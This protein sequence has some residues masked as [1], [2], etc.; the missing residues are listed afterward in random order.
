MTAPTY[1]LQGPFHR[2]GRR[3]RACPAVLSAAH[4]STTCA[5]PE[6][7]FRARWSPTSDRAPVSPP[8]SF[9]LAATRSSVSSPTPRCELQQRTRWRSTRTFVRRRDRPRRPACR[10]GARPRRRGAGFSL[11]RRRPHAR[12]VPAHSQGR[13]LGGAD[14]ERPPVHRYRVP[15]RR[16]KLCCSNSA[17]TMPRSGIAASATERLADFFGGPF[18]TRRYDNSPGARPRRPALAPAVVVLHPCRRRTGARRDA[19]SPDGDLR[20]PCRGRAGGGS[21]TTPRSTPASCTPP[22]EA[23]AACSEAPA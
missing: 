7:C 6:L 11:V 14:L 4:C 19:R 20:G 8:S 3:L 21:S 2:P 1:R 17:R 13:R 5:R 16:T 22:S 23:K 12:R 10:T 9:S 18:T 15:R